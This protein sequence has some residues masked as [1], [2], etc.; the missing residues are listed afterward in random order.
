MKKTL[1]RLAVLALAAA[2]VLAG[3]AAP[4]AAATDS[5]LSRTTGFVAATT[6]TQVL[7]LGAY[8]NVHV[9]DL[10]AFETRVGFA[11]V[12][13][14]IQDFRCP[15]GELPPTGH[16][17]EDEEGGCEF[18]GSRLLKGQD[19]PFTVTRKAATATLKGT[20]VAKT[21]G[22]PHT[23]EGGTTLGRVP[24]NFTW[25]SVSAPARVRSTYTYQEDGETMSETYR[26]TSRRTTMSGQLGPMLFQQAASAEGR[27]E[28]FRSTTRFRG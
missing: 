1:V 3:T 5:Y 6:W 12:F 19:V 2:P 22:D 4:A 10:Q 26:A 20:L 11:D 21:A 16:G 14:F 18:V 23:G 9:G 7:D 28:S 13:S 27:L 24:A 17:E 8:G 15:A 25:T